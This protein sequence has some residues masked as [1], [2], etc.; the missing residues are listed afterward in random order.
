MADKW[1]LNIFSSILCLKM[2]Y[3]SVRLWFTLLAI[4]FF[5]TEKAIAQQA[6]DSLIIIDAIK[7]VGNQRTQDRIL[8]REL[9]YKVGD[10]VHAHDTAA[11]FHHI[12]EK[13]YNQ[14]LFNKTSI[15]L[16]NQTKTDSQTIK[17]ATL[18]ML[19]NERWF[20]FPIPIIELADRSFNEWYYNRNADLSR[21]NYG[22]R[23]TQHNL[24]G[25]ND[26]LKIGVQLG[27]THRADITYR[28][29][30]LDKN[31]KGGLSLNASYST[32]V[33]AAA[34]TIENKQNFIDGKNLQTL[35]VRR[36]IGL[37]Y[38]RRNGFYTYIEA[39]INYNNNHIA[40]TIAQVNPDYYG[41]SRTNQRFW[42][43][44]FTYSY[45]R[46]NYQRFATKGYY[47]G[48]ELEQNGLIH[49]DA[50]N[51]TSFR[52]KASKYYTLT[53]RWYFAT[54]ADVLI[55][56]QDYMPYSNLYGIGYNLRFVRGYDAQV[57]EAP[58]SLIWK[59]ALRYKVFS[60]VFPVRY[61]PL[62][63]FKTLPLALYIKGYADAGYARNVF[64]QESNKQLSNR[65]LPGYGLGIDLVSFYDLVMRFEYSF[66]YK[67]Q[68]GFY[69]YLGADI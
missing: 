56:L 14:R 9:E 2:H 42:Q 10:T 66:N 23:F 35:R 40:D 50:I 43:F 32:N 24:T 17:H 4:L 45:D 48:G 7:L 38:T 61:S 15:A 51:Q 22:L 18:L 54:G 8:L 25:N 27:F 19:V 11:K 6:N 52:L 47:L 36:I 26:P 58:Q 62:E 16:V 60:R 68:P 69:F 37:S 33:S 21:I 59:N 67:A 53:P 13:L 30:Y 3:Y 55:A 64:A 5:F 31:Q 49:S 65:I 46:R 1:K 57:I 39:G 20:T 34:N 29:P 44:R 28:F 41:S 12:N 63:Q